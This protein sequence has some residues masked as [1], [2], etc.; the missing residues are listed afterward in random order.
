MSSSLGPEFHLISRICPQT[1]LRHGEVTALVECLWFH[2]RV[3]TD[4][5]FF[6][7]HRSS[8]VHSN[9]EI[10]G[11]VKTAVISH[12]RSSHPEIPCYWFHNFDESSCCTGN[13][14]TNMLCQELM[15][16]AFK[17]EGL[18]P[19]VFEGAYVRGNDLAVKLQLSLLIGC[20]RGE[21]DRQKELLKKR[22]WVKQWRPEIVDHTFSNKVINDS[23]NLAVE[24]LCISSHTILGLFQKAFTAFDFMA[25]IRLSGWK[26]AWNAMC[27]FFSSRGM[28]FGKNEFP[29]VRAVLG[30]VER[31]YKDEEALINY[32][33][34]MKDVKTG[35]NYMDATSIVI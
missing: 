24:K 5:C 19:D 22:I 21:I 8:S 29:P 11:K 18:L 2:F 34:A 26:I 27:I 14:N 33:K 12:C 25:F 1:R 20:A 15:G 7:A 35:S 17:K 30:D 6:N 3:V 4:P 10:T 32:T 16:Q 13:Y 31:E 23:M 28:F 9:E